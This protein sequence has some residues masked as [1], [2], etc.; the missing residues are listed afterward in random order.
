MY[1]CAM[2]LVCESGMNV[3]EYLL[4]MC[5]TLPYDII[6][7]LMKMGSSNKCKSV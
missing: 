7:L 6:K 5:C 2:K 4:A 3:G 1:Y